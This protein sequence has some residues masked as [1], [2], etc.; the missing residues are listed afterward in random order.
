MKGFFCKLASEATLRT[1]G[2]V[3]GHIK[4][5]WSGF[6][7]ETSSITLCERAYIRVA[8]KD[9]REKTK[10]HMT[11]LL[12]SFTLLQ[13]KWWLLIVWKSRSLIFHLWC[14][15]AITVTTS[16]SLST[17]QQFSFRS[18]STM[19]GLQSLSVHTV[20]PLEVSD[21]YCFGLWVTFSWNKMA[22]AILALVQ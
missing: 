11:Q 1:C 17:S 14:T 15:W 22:A 4:G 13:V 18:T 3:S 19:M 8:F 7:P 5:G 20:A 6:L 16:A 12:L 9:H 21:I 10:R 2:V